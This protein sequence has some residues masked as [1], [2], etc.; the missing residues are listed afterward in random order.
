MCSERLVVEQP[1]PEVLLIKAGSDGFGS[2]GS[3]AAAPHH[4]LR[5]SW[6]QRHC[7][8][9]LR[10]PR[11]RPQ[12]NAAGVAHGRKSGCQQKCP[13][14]HHY[15]GEFTLVC[16]ETGSWKKAPGEHLKISIIW[17][18]KATSLAERYFVLEVK[19]SF[20]NSAFT[21][22]WSYKLWSREWQT[23]MRHTKE[24]RS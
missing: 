22:N 4:S 7:A 12:L 8:L 17:F 14:N 19:S 1:G 16:T 13:Q 11:A 15:F 24:K 23:G 9:A 3:R 18:R 10:P 5:L 21:I 2:A 6:R 20:Q